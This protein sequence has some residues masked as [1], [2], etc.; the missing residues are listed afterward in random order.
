MSDSLQHWRD[1]EELYHAALERE[2]SAA[3]RF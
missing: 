3:Q 2:P 1:L